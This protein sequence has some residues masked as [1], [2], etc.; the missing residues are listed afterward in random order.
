MPCV[1]P[2]P[3]SSAWLGC[4][5]KWGKVELRNLPAPSYSRLHRR[6]NFLSNFGAKFQV[7]I[8]AR[9]DLGKYFGRIFRKVDLYTG[10]TG[11]R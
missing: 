11:G 6:L 2:P 9:L 1:S 3:P 8:A 4:W 7:Y 5:L 10:F